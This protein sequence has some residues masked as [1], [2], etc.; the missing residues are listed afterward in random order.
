MGKHKQNNNREDTKQKQWSAVE[1]RRGERT[2]DEARFECQELQKKID[3]LKAG[4]SQGGTDQSAQE[5]LKKLN[6]EL[7][8]ER[9]KVSWGCEFDDWSAW[10]G[11]ISS[12]ALHT[13]SG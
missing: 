10:G 9:K 4:K 1:E 8:E 6:S 5:E 3:A 13:R 7:K 12:P 11:L 2:L